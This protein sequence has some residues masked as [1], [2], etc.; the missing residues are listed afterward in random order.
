MTATD[1]ENAVLASFLYADDMG[2]DT[3]KAFQLSE[4]AFTSDFRRRV[5]VKINATTATDKAYAVLSYDIENKIG[6]TVFEQQWNEIVS[7]SG[8]SQTPLPF[9]LAL[10]YHD[11]IRKAYDNNIAKGLR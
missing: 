6:G 8:L 7:A 10:R 3:S 11:D 2:E 5:A 4:D 1:R 9:S